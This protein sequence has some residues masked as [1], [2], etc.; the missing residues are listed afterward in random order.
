MNSFY[1]L[2]NSCG[3]SL[4]PQMI[5]LDVG[6]GLGMH[7][8][9]LAQKFSEVYCADIINYSTL[10]DRALIKLL[11]EKYRRNNL[12]VP[13]ERIRFFET[14]ATNLFFEND[15]F[16]LSISINS[17]EH[18]SDPHQAL[19]EM[20]RVTKP[21]GYIYISFD[22]IWTADSG[23]HFFHLVPQPW[24]HLLL[25]KEQFIA[26]MVCSGASNDDVKDFSEGINRFRL[27]QYENIIEELLRNRKAILEYKDRYVGTIEPDHMYHPNYERA[28]SIDFGRL[29]L[30]V[31]R[32]RF[33]LSK[34]SHSFNRKA[35][36]WHHSH[37]FRNKIHQIIAEILVR[38]DIARLELIR[39]RNRKQF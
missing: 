4:S 6:A 29:E 34:P 18:I 17:L 9:Y 3:I 26:K 24:E 13:M 8:A 21:G 30:L 7:A 31:R 36:F 15:F 37:L 16:D 39:L 5:V 12:S 28:I 33:I 10:Y 14:D 20:L 23:S 11:E 19:A 1:D 2:F 22:P 35:I 25:N 27:S 38:R 32:L